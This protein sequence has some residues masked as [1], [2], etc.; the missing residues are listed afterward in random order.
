MKT[1][2]MFSRAGTHVTVVALLMTIL[3]LAG[4]ITV[5]CPSGNCQP[6]CSSGDGPPVK[7]VGVPINPGEFGCSSGLKCS[8]ATSNK[9]CGLPGAGTLCTTWND[10]GVCKCDCK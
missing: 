7:C 10:N 6:P 8:A 1:F 9:P 5:T 2:L 4:C 3:L